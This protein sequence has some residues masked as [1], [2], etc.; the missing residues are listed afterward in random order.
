[1]RH[2]HLWLT[3]TDCKPWRE[4]TPNWPM[5]TWNCK[6]RTRVCPSSCRS[7]SMLTIQRRERTISRLLKMRY[8][9][10][11][12]RR[13]KIKMQKVRVC[14][15]AMQKW[16]SRCRLSWMSMQCSKV[17]T[18]SPRP[19][20]GRCLS[21]RTKKST[22]LSLSKVQ[23]PVERKVTMGKH[24]QRLTYRSQKRGKILNSLT[25]EHLAV[26]LPSLM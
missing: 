26:Q 15:K 4:T 20:Q 5:K 25:V 9:R 16:K 7:R 12:R 18:K 13:W 22:N 1:M 17:I 23:D 8:R 6:K 21:K 11:S 10:G 24:S 3:R 19:R 14:G 2:R